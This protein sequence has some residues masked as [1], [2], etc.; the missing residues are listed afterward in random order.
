MLDWQKE[1][2]LAFDEDGAVSLNAKKLFRDNNIFK[3]NDDAIEALLQRLLIANVKWNF[4]PYILA[5]SSELQRRTN[6]RQHSNTW[7]IAG[8]ALFIS[9]VSAILQAISIYFSCK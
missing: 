2:E 8:V 1:L 3:M 6:E 4:E 9:V 7:L 5:V